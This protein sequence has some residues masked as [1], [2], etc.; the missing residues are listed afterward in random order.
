MF[1]LFSMI[2]FASCVNQ[3]FVLSRIAYET[4]RF[5]VSQ[6][7]LSAGTSLSLFDPKHPESE[8][9]ESLANIFAGQ[10]PNITGTNY[11]I[12]PDKTLL[13]EVSTANTHLLALQ[14]LEYQ[15]LKYGGFNFFSSANYLAITSKYYN[16]EDELATKPSGYVNQC[17]G[18]NC[19][20]F[21]VTLSVPYSPI[22]FRWLQLPGGLGFDLSNFN[23]TTSAVAPYMLR[24]R[25]G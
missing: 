1:I 12:C 25:S 5:G 14:L 10:Y 21:K 20:T 6:M 11:T 15:Q 17:P 3:Y 8:C 4:A 7:R 2:E 18:T 13:T 24:D 23:I 16:P 22:M 19:N 9:N